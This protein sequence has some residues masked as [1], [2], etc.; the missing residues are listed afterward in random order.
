MPSLM[1]LLAYS[2]PGKKLLACVHALAEINQLKS[3]TQPFSHV[4]PFT[5]SLN[6]Q[7]QDQRGSLPVSDLSLLVSPSLPSPTPSSPPVSGTPTP[8][9][10][11][12]TAKTA[13]SQLTLSGYNT[14]HEFR[15]RSGFA[16]QE[17]TILLTHQTSTRLKKGDLAKCL[18]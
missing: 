17:V 2:A 8:R 10:P 1:T 14:D 7:R 3:F 13:G 5:V 9:D 6:L 16:F 15:K 4:G 11:S 12:R 18:L